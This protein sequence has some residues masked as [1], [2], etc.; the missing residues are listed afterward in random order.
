MLYFA[1][2]LNLFGLGF[3]IFKTFWTRVGIGLSFEN[4]DWIWITKYDSPLI[5]DTT[6]RCHRYLH[7]LDLL[8]QEQE[9]Q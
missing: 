8:R 2:F 3:R 9:K 5:S 6:Y 1:K 4:Q 7:H